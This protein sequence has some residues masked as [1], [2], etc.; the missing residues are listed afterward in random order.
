MWG[1]ERRRALFISSAVMSMKSGTYLALDLDLD[2]LPGGT[3]RGGKR[4]VLCGATV[5][6]GRE[7]RGTDEARGEKGGHRPERGEDS[8]ARAPCI[9]IPRP[10]P[11][12][13]P[14]AS[15]SWAP[16]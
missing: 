15:A 11:A 16:A 8:Q 9:F 14:R 13:F 3:I 4:R 2:L 5:P 7:E 10:S 12:N 1:K 6:P